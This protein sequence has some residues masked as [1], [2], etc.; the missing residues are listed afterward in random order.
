M[1][2]QTSPWPTLLNYSFL[3]ERGAYAA[4]RLRP[5]VYCRPVVGHNSAGRDYGPGSRGDHEVTSHA[6]VCGLV[7]IYA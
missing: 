4:R 3:R 7:A 5:R 6:A 1:P 2:H